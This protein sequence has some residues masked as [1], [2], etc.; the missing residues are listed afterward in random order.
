MSAIGTAIL[1]LLQQLLPLITSGSAASGVVTT[2]VNLLTTWLPLITTEVT[3]LYTPIKNIIAALNSSGAL[4]DQQIADLKTSEAAIDA[5]FDAAS[6]G[7][8]PDAPATA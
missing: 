7:L 4:T 3:A 6:A 5:A 8:D 2:V 1:A